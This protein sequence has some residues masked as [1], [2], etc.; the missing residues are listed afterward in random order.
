M[1]T[2]TFTG[3]IGDA[4]L[5]TNVILPVI[6]SI[7]AYKPDGDPVS[8]NGIKFQVLVLGVLK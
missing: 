2:L 4:K 7:C 1:T 6:S 8:L 5:N 3:L